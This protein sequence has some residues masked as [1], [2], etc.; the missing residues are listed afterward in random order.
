MSAR[1][2]RLP[3]GMRNTLPHTGMS[4]LPRISREAEVTGHQ[5]GEIVRCFWAHLFQHAPQLDNGEGLLAHP[6]RRPDAGVTGL[7]LMDEARLAFMQ[8]S[9]PVLLA[10]WSDISVNASKSR[11]AS[12]NDPIRL[13]LDMHEP[14]NSTE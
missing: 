12:R 6:A 5:G 13:I 3:H 11:A 1:L 14:G 9:L 8:L 7:Y 2:G 4:R 10:L